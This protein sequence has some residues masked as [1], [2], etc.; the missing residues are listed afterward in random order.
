MLVASL[1]QLFALTGAEKSKII[2]RWCKNIYDLIAVYF[3]ETSVQHDAHS[4]TVPCLE[5]TSPN[6]DKKK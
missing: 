1:L 3:F 2:L 4:S 5:T 6:G